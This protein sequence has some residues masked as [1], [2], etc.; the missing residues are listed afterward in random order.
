MREFFFPRCAR[1]KCNVNY[2]VIHNLGGGNTKN[3]AVIP[4]LGGNPIFW[5][6]KCRIY[7]GCG[8][9]VIPF[10]C[11][12]RAAATLQIARNLLNS[13]PHRL[14]LDVKKC[15]AGKK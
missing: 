9:F 11:G 3:I 10:F 1:G 2:I 12:E 13:V 4:I 5:A 15:A 7:R 6:E 14:N 8:H